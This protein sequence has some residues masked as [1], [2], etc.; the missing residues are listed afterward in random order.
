MNPNQPSDV[1]L[2]NDESN[3]FS[4]INELANNTEQMIRARR[5]KERHRID[6]PATLVPG[7]LTDRQSSVWMGTCHD[8]S[9]TGCR[10]V[11]NRPVNVG[12]IYFLS[13][14]TSELEFDPH[15]VRCIRCHMLREDSFECGFSFFTEVELFKNRLETKCF[16]IS[17]KFVNQTQMLSW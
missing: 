8:I 3:I 17:R 2:S 10:V 14:E 16:W 6:A 1:D 11:L 4:A 12:D 15:F 13:L 9:S 7:N 5:T